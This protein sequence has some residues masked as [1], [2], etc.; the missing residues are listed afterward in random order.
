MEEKRR[1]GG[2]SDG[3]GVKDG[4]KAEEIRNMGK[5]EEKKME[6]DIN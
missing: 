1:R 2:N 4:G 5:E 6:E 3:K